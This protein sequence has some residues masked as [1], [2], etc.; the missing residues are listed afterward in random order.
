[1]NRGPV[2]VSTPRRRVESSAGGTLAHLAPKVGEVVVVSLRAGSASPI[3]HPDLANAP[4]DRG[5][6][7]AEL[8]T[9]AGRW[10]GARRIA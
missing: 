4:R 3:A 2:A 1:M 9:A 5:V 10:T 6:R 7:A 8:R